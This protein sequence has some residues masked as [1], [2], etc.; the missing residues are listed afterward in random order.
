MQQETLTELLSSCFHWSKSCK[1]VYPSE[2]QNRCWFRVE[3]EVFGRES[4]RDQMAFFSP[5]FSLFRMSCALSFV[6]DALFSLFSCKKKIGFLS[7][8]AANWR[9]TPPPPVEWSGAN[10]FLLFFHSWFFFPV[11]FLRFC[12][13]SWVWKNNRNKIKKS[14]WWSSAETDHK[15]N[16]G[17]GPMHLHL[18]KD[19]FLEE[20]EKTFFNQ[21]QHK[22]RLRIQNFL[23][24][25]HRQKVNFE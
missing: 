22:N 5:S 6:P 19:I 18:G 12:S 13:S 14:C 1:L 3:V 9:R 25:W 15:P 4:W 2:P 24:F 16:Q 8:K 21:K 11:L 17:L 10:A 20:L 23:F 7:K